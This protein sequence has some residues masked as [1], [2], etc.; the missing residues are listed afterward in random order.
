LSD[1][2][3]VTSDRLRWRSGKRLE[4]SDLEGS[5]I[6]ALIAGGH[7]A[8][9]PSKKTIIPAEPDAPTPTSEEE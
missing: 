3:I 1:S 7:L 5:N 9:A 2:Y 8:E 4:A 6:A